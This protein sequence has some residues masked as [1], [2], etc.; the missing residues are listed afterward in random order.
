MENILSDEHKAN[1]QSL[2]HPAIGLDS[3]SHY[4]V[5]EILNNTLALFRQL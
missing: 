4:G 1:L 2:I 3:D 5:V